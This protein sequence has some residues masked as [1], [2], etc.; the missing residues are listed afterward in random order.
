MEEVRLEERREGRVATES[1]PPSL[2][3]VAL[4]S[5]PP[6]PAPAPP[7]PPSLTHSLLSSFSNTQQ[8]PA[9]G[10]LCLAALNLHALRELTG[11]RKGKGGG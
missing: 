7:L 6:P 10:L 4:L 9:P 8:A 5:L 11:R 3:E 1:L 2:S